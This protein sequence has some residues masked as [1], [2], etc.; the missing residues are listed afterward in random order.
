MVKISEKMWNKIMFICMGEREKNF[1]PTYKEIEDYISYSSSGK[2]SFRENRVIGRSKMIEIAENC[3]EDFVHQELIKYYKYVPYCDIII[4]NFK[5]N[6][7]K[8]YGEKESK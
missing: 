1:V 3:G 8:K 2:S 5:I 4:K 6:M 7:S